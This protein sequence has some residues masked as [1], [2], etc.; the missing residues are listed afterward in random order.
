MD[1]HKLQLKEKLHISLDIEE[2]AETFA[3]QNK[4]KLHFKVNHLANC[5]SIFRA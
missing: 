3:G 2:F 1:W 5:S 4:K